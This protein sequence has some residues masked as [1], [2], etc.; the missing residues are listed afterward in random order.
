MDQYQHTF[1]LLD[2]IQQALVTLNL[3]QAMPPEAAAFESTE[4]FSID[5]MS[6]EQW[7]Q[8]VFLP[9]MQ[10]LLDAKAPLP[11]RFSIAPYVEE[12][13]KTHPQISLLLAP[14][15]ELDSLFTREA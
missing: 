12:A 1:L 13:L 4:P 15:Q 9:R 11:T 10:A 8:W 7:L 3:W 6:A 5:T 14:L 2:N